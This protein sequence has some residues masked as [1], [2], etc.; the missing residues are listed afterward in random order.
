MATDK[1]A[2]TVAAKFRNILIEQLGVEEPAI[3]DDANLIHDLGADE[4]D[5]VEITM[6]CEEEFGITL[7]EDKVDKA[8]T[9]AQ[10]LKLLTATIG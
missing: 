8:E 9:V 5:I 4:L 2:A 6:V 3:T 10:F 7:D 1:S